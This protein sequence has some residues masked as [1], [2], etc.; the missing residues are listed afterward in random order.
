[1]CIIL[2]GMCRLYLYSQ[3]AKAYSKQ[4]PERRRIGAR[5]LISE[6]KVLKVTINNIK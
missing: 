5:S 1:M 2:C 6:V 3:A 4:G